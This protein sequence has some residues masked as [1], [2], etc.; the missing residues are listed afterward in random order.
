MG[1]NVGNEGRERWLMLRP[2]PHCH[3]HSRIGKGA[4]AR[5]F[6]QTHRVYRVRPEVVIIDIVLLVSY[7]GPAAF[8]KTACST[9]VPGVDAAADPIQ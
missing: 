6:E 3:E 1:N 2:M 4:K 8:V 7:C 9:S 5:H